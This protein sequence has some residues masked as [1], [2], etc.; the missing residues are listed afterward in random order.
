MT[1]CLFFLVIAFT[2]AHNRTLKI[3]NNLL[4][5]MKKPNIFFQDRT[6]WSAQEGCSFTGCCLVGAMF[7]LPEVG[8][9]SIPFHPE[10]AL[11]MLSSS[12]GFTLH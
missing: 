8:L 10:Q 6:I 12:L 1:L 3:N 9:L 7:T 5:C 2:H 11:L 4:N